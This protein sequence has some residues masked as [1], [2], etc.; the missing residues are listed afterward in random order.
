MLKSMEGVLTFDSTVI[1]GDRKAVKPNLLW[2]GSNLFLIDHSVAIPVHLWPEEQLL[3]SPLFPE[4][5]VRVHCAFD[6]LRRRKQQYTEL[7]QTWLTRIQSKDFDNLRALI[8]ASWE[9][10]EGDLDKI[11]RFLK[12]RPSRSTEISEDLRR[13]VL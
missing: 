9:K 5:N 12:E 11:F 7:L 2:N 13:I 8:P 6:I 4:D 3:A 1:N 10:R